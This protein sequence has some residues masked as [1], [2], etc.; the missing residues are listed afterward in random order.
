MDFDSVQIK[1]KNS[2]QLKPIMQEIQN[3]QISNHKVQSNINPP[4][5][6]GVLQIE[7][8]FDIDANSIINV[9]ACHK[10]SRKEQAITIQSS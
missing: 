4:S 7:V 3:T 10:A 2:I 5:L 8:T 9:Y 1:P 6:H